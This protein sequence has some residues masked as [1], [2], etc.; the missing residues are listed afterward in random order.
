[1]DGRIIDKLRCFDLDIITAYRPNIV[2]L[3]IGTNDLSSVELEVVGSGID[4]L[5]QFL[6]GHVSVRVICWCCEIPHAI[7]HAD[8]GLFHQR[9]KIL[10]NYVKV[11]LDPL[12]G[13]FC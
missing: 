11:V 7:S 1:M 2:I 10:N 4:D 13:F 6:F 12:P 3:E 9:A 5:V 8:T